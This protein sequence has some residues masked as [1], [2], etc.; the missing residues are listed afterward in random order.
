[1]SEDIEYNTPPELKD[2]F[3]A[4]S[5]IPTKSKDKYEQTY[6]KFV[7]WLTSHQ[8]T[9]QYISQNILIPYFQELSQKKK[10]TTLWS[11]FSMLKKMLSIKHGV[12]IGKMPLLKDYLKKIKWKYKEKEIQYIHFRRIEKVS[13]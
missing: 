5:L 13:S 10:P 11:I 2:V 12:D 8:G 7:F 9:I 3:Q 4:D 1:M 6:T